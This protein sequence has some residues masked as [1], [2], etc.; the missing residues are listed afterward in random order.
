M[1][2]PAQVLFLKGTITGHKIYIVP[3]RVKVTFS[4]VP[5]RVPVALRI[6]FADCK[7]VSRHNADKAQPKKRNSH[8]HRQARSAKSPK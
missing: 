3:R 5:L 8:R 7:N 2:S 4:I 6:P 1:C